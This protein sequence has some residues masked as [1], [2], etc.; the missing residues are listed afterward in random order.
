MTDQLI[1]AVIEDFDM[2]FWSI[3]WFMVKVAFASI[4]AIVVVWIVTLVLFAIFGGIGS[5]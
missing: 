5:H 3:V 4:P 1:R 2:K